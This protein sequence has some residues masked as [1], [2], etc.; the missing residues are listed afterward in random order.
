MLFDV[1]FIADWKKIGEYMHSQ[2][3][4]NTARE[5]KTRIHWDY[6]TRDKVLLRKDGILPQSDSLYECDPWTITVF[7]QMGQ[8]GF[9]AEVNLRDKTLGES[10]LILLQV[11]D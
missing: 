4:K 5:N 8:L 1:P 9:D 2:I 6:Q 11:H 7:I 10:H 3:D